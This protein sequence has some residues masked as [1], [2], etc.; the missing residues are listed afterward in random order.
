MRST[1]TILT[2]L[3]GTSLTLG[4][5][6]AEDVTLNVFHPF[7]SHSKR[8]YE[9]IADEFMKLHPDVKITFRA[10]A[11]NYN[12]GHL[13][14]VRQA[15]TNELPDVWFSGYNLL[16]ELVDTLEKRDQIVNLSP[17]LDAEGAAWVKENYAPNVLEL[18]QVRGAQ[19]GMP[20]AASTPIVYYNLDLVKKAGGDPTNLPTDWDGIL[21]LA[22]KIH[23]LGDGVDGLTVNLSLDDDWQWQA[24]LMGYGGQFMD[25]EKKTVTFGDEA[26]LAAVTLIQ[27]LGKEA[28]MP[29]LN[30]EQGI[31]QFV[32]G[33]MGMFFGSTAEVRTMDDAV[34]GKFEVKTGAFPLGDKD[35]G[36]L[37]SG[38]NAAVILTADPAKQKAAWEY[39]KYSTSPA[40]QK[41]VVLG[42]G[43]MPTNL[44]TTEPE[45]LGNF[46]ADRPNWTTSMKQWP[47]ATVWFGY[48]GSKGVKIWREQSPILNSIADGGTDPKAG[49]EQLVKATQ[50]LIDE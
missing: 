5:A 34:K 8:F 20:F 3:A 44:K 17:M 46:Y 37:P 31:Q 2:L 1:I 43:Y 29:L 48:P 10:E 6:A 4:S 15:L 19:W 22:K 36:R 41:L 16:G 49:L 12:E 14:V 40:G 13:T 24:I 21:D 7:G 25:A 9:P 42:S 33:K 18:G 45:Y 26:G 27:R 35:K 50:T 23:A 28:S 39:I 32:A 47:L 38:G 11:Q 30:E